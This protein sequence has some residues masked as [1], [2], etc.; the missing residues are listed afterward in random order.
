MDQLGSIGIEFDEVTIDRI[1]TR[2]RAY[3]HQEA[4]LV[5]TRKIKPPH[6]SR[7]HRLG[8]PEG[9]AVAAAFFHGGSGRPKWA[10]EPLY[11]NNAP[12]RPWGLAA[13]QEVGG[14]LYRLAG[15][16]ARRPGRYRRIDPRTGSATAA[17]LEDTNERVHASVRVRLAVS[18]LGLNDSG[19]WDCPA[20]LNRWTLRQVPVARDEGGRESGFDDPVP[21][22]TRKW[23]P[24]ADGLVT[25]I[26]GEMEHDDDDGG[27][28]HRPPS[29][30]AADTTTRWV[31]DY[32]GPE[33][34]APP[35]RRLVEE[36]LGPYERHLL[37]LSGGEPNVFRFAEG[38]TFVPEVLGRKPEID[39]G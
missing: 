14:F 3:Y 13:I 25:C 27:G 4:T 19:F 17:F 22:G 35:V 1:F 7:R 29:P 30:G 37:K 6:R 28:C 21:L 23:G 15:R 2:A 32:V 8:G 20:L 31:W 5:A 34:D 24:H 36:V 38:R 16:R 11:G 26:H 33:R 9:N 10:V 18:G 39:F 12:A